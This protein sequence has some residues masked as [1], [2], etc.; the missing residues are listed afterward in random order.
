MVGALV[1]AAA[2]LV[3]EEPVVGGGLGIVVARAVDDDDDVVSMVV[4]GDVVSSPLHALATRTTLTMTSTAEL[5][6]RSDRIM[7]T[8]DFWRTATTWL[9]APGVPW[10]TAGNDPS[11]KDLLHETRRISLLSWP[12][13]ERSRD[14]GPFPRANRLQETVTHFPLRVNS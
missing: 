7:Q 1:L 8:R 12:A 4:D 3:L 2:V 11:T 14:N 9:F 10:R 5:R 6:K 13:Y